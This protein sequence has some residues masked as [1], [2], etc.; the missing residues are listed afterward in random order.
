ML[1]R[2]LAWIQ[3]HVIRPK[4]VESLLEV[5]QVVVLPHALYQHVVHVNLHIPPNL[6]CEHFVHL[7]LMCGTRI[8]VSKRHHYVAEET[9]VGDK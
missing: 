1:F 6:M 4:G 5:V 7:P 8:L 9:L 3:F 2:S